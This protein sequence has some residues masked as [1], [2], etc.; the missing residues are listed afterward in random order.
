LIA[1]FASFIYR[2]KDITNAVSRTEAL[3]IACLDE[4]G[5]RGKNIIYRVEKSWEKHNIKG[6]TVRYIFDLETPV[7]FTELTS[8]VKNE[9]KKFNDV[10][11]SRIVYKKTGRGGGMIALEITADDNLILSVKINNIK[12]AWTLGGNLGKNSNSHLL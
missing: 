11:L 1:F 3:L 6:K 10:D 12:P 5:M 4:F 8:K 9:L 7:S 2:T